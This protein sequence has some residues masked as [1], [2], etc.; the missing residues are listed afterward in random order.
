VGILQELVVKGYIAAFVALV[1]LTG[2]VGLAQTPAPTRVGVIQ[3]QGALVNT[4]DGQ[5]ALADF[6]ARLEPKK[7]DLEK[8]QN[9]IRELQDRLQ[10]GGNALSDS[11][12]ADM[13]R[14]IDQKTRTYNRDVQ[15]AQEDAQM[16]QQ[17]VM[18]DLLQK[19]MPVIS[20]Y[21]AANGYSMI[22]DAGSPNSPVLFATESANITKDII[23]LYDEQSV[24]PAS[25]SAGAAATK[26]AT[27]ETKTPPSQ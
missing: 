27:P 23:N 17:K 3:L 7:K 8:Q 13:T 14:D 1:S 21:A 4:K 25:G 11:A 15:D 24:L 19:M 18:R 16:E 12:R 5:K 20:K 26:P 22:L 10:R 9:D 6:Q 2:T